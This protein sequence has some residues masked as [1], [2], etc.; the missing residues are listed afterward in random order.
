MNTLTLIDGYDRHT[1]ARKLT[2]RNPTSIQEMVSW[3]DSH[4]HIWFKSLDGTARRCRVNGKVRTWKRDKDRVEVPVK[5]G[6]YEYGC[7]TQ[8]DITRVLI[9]IGDTQDA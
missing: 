2:F 9:P 8:R 6:M 3:C 4:N 1:P 5:Y 7:F